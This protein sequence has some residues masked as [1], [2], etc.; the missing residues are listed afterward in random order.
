MAIIPDL[1]LEIDSTNPKTAYQTSAHERSLADSPL[2]SRAKTAQVA[3]QTSA[4]KGSFAESRLPSAATTTTQP[5]A[6]MENKTAPDDQKEL[7]ELYHRN[8]QKW[9]Q[10]TRD[11]D[12]EAE[13]NALEAIMAQRQTEKACQDIC[14][15][16]CE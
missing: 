4:Q 16:A 11:F 9:R 13:L 6:D 10:L 1:S 12:V 5:C 7:E 3:D 15:E 2:P 8:L 14:G